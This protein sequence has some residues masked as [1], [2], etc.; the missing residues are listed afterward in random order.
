MQYAGLINQGATC[1]IN[2]FVQVLF[3]TPEFRSLIFN[4]KYEKAKHGDEKNC[5]ALQLQKLFDLMDIAQQLCEPIDLDTI[6]LTKSFGLNETQVKQQQDICEFRMIL[7]DELETKYFKGTSVEGQISKLYY[8]KIKSK[9]ESLESDYS[10]V[11]IE[12]FNCLNIQLPVGDNN[13]DYSLNDGITDYFREI[14]LC[15]ND[16]YYDQK[17]KR[18]VIAS[19]IKEIVQYPEHLCIELGR[20]GCSNEM[21]NML[22]VHIP[23]TLKVDLTLYEIYAIVMH[24][25]YTR[26]AGHYYVYIRNESHTWFSFNDTDVMEVNEDHV[27]Y[28]AE[29]K[30]VEDENAYMI[31]YRK[32]KID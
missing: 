30:L 15:G 6:D 11:T 31:L 12:S 10:S 14:F 17:L 5:F 13:V 32:I 26:L 8:G 24:V 1:Y 25:G 23:F 4:W 16:A 19:Q 22:Q 29:G 7:L 20:F 18:D 3:M 28:S 9:I 27:S 21:K 2:T